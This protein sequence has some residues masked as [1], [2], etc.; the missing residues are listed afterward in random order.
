MLHMTDRERDDR[1]MTGRIISAT[2][3]TV[4]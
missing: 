2:V 1:R 4:S 3:S